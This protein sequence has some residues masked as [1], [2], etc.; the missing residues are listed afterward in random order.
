[1][2]ISA[3]HMRRLARLAIIAVL[4]GVC[5]AAGRA[6]AM[7]ELPKE[8]LGPPVDFRLNVKGEYE[9]RPF[10]IDE[11]VTCN[12]ITLSGGVGTKR[13]VGF[14]RS[15]TTFGINT[16]SKKALY[17]TVPD[18]CN[19]LLVQHLTREEPRSETIERIAGAY[20]V[21]PLIY[22][23]E[24]YENPAFVDAFFVYETDALVSDR[25][26]LEKSNVEFGP[27]LTTAVSNAYLEDERF[28]PLGAVKVRSGLSRT[29]RRHTNW[30]GYSLAPYPT[31]TEFVGEPSSESL[32]REIIIPSPNDISRMSAGYWALVTQANIVWTSESK[33][34]FGV[35][36]HPNAV[37]VFRQTIPLRFDGEGLWTSEDFPEAR[38][39]AMRFYPRRSVF[40]AFKPENR[41][42]VKLDGK[43]FRP[44]PGD[45]YEDYRLAVDLGGDAPPLFVRRHGL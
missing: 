30:V 8:V 40:A 23:V 5:A 17:I 19:R 21:F 26:R 44:P 27:N 31:D 34:R 6:D 1:M 37:G 43:L 22:A 28:D 14:E 29:N 18:V 13:S 36:G 12:P 24:D 33:I 4:I 25:L 9:G 35:K 39:E 20:E 10:E 2:A 11:L 42:S 7:G 45:E 32:L 38:V 3:E 41:H 16:S 15:V